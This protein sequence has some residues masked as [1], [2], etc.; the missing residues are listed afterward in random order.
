VSIPYAG[1]RLL[2][3]QVTTAFD[4]AGFCVVAN[5]GVARG[6]VVRSRGLFAKMLAHVRSSI[7]GNIALYAD[8][9]ERARRDAYEGCLDHAKAMGGNAIIGLRYDANEIAP[10]I[11]EVLCYG[12]AVI[13]EPKRSSLNV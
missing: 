8:L 2:D 6:I 1:S 11:T 10:G 4:L 3:E 9:C 5:V 7:G 12:S 13:V